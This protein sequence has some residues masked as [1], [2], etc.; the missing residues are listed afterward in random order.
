[1]ADLCATDTKACTG[2]KAHYWAL[3][4]MVGSGMFLLLSVNGLLVLVDRHLRQ[5]QVWGRPDVMHA[6][7]MGTVAIFALLALLDAVRSFREGN[8][9][10]LAFI[11]VLMAWSIVI[12]LA[13]VCLLF[14]FAADFA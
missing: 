5:G 6:G 2:R 12:T 9:R 4:G 7:V 3:V 10:R 11:G 1:M 8:L 14:R 13:L